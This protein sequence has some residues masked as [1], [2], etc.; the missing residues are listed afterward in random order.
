[1]QRFIQLVHADNIELTH[2]VLRLLLKTAIT[3]DV[4]IFE[5]SGSCSISSPGVEAS[6][7]SHS[8]QRHLCTAGRSPRV[9][10]LLRAGEIW[11]VCGFAV[12]SSLWIS[13]DSEYQS[14]KTGYLQINRARRRITAALTKSSLPCFMWVKRKCPKSKDDTGIKSKCAYLEVKTYS[15]FV[16]QILW[17]PNKSTLC[18]C[19]YH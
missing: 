6:G 2:C 4:V 8:P 19:G 11:R 16:G 13:D 3:L 9:S 12:F 7:P 5:S 17:S 10:H 18:D 15:L 14:S 1:M